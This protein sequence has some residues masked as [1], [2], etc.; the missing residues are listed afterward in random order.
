MAENKPSIL[1]FKCAEL[2]FIMPQLLLCVDV[3][4]CTRLSFSLCVYFQLVVLN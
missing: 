4:V 3:Y 1:I 2:L